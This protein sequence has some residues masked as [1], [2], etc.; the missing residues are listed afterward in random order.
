MTSKTRDGE[1]MTDED[2][3]LW[4]LNHDMIYYEKDIK[5]LAK[6]HSHTNTIIHLLRNELH[7]A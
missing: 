4:Q 3:Q 5:E 1:N 6:E 7:G 2:M